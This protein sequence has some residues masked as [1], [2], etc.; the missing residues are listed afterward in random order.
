M[1]K[2][3]QSLIKTACGHKVKSHSEK[4]VDNW[5]FKNGWLSIY[6]PPMRFHEGNII[7]P[8]WVLL[9]QKGISKPVIIEYWG[10]S[11]L[12][13]NAARWAIKAQEKYE[14]RKKRKEQHYKDSELYHYIGLT[15]PDLKNLEE[16][17]GK[18]LEMLIHLRM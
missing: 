5:L 13:P 14:R 10:L 7:K 11:V 2:S 6:E 1:A 4:K 17:L 16:S 3:R 18:K 8:D 9:P 15:R 12:K